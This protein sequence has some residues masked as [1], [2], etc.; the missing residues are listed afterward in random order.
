MFSAAGCYNCHRVA[1]EGSS[2][3]PDLTGVGGR[4]GVRDLMRAVVEPNQQISDQYQQMVFETDGRVDRRPRH[5]HSAARTSMISTDMLD[6]KKIESIPRGEID[7]QYPSDVSMMPAG[8]LNTLTAEEILD[9]TAFL[10]SGGEPRARIL[11][12]L[13]AASSR[14]CAPLWQLLAPRSAAASF[15]RDARRRADSC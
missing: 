3:G 13:P 1:G 9:L 11:P 10:R 6:P 5:E 15:S 7:D 2:V 14:P 4:F 8:L 12:R